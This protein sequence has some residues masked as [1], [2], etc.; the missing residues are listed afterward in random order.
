VVAVKNFSLFS[1]CLPTSNPKISLP[2][3]STKTL[4]QNSYTSISI[5]IYIQITKRFS[6]FSDIHHFGETEA[7]KEWCKY[8]N[9]GFSPKG[10][11][12]L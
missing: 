11:K 7:L 2:N 9:H 12:F 5:S 6:E 4:S 3:F 10:L 8:Q 1:L